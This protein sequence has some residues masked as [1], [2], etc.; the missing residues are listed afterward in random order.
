M[1]VDQCFRSLEHITKLY[2]EII[3]RPIPVV[4][5]IYTDSLLF[6]CMKATVPNLPAIGY[7]CREHIPG[8][9]VNYMCLINGLI[10][11]ADALKNAN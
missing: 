8:G 10:N 9:R 7:R 5:H 11:T 4:G 3:R 2:Q 6:K 1:T